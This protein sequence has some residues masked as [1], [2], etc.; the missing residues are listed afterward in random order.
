M[1]ASRDWKGE[2]DLV[3]ARMINEQVYCPRLAHLEWVQGEFR[4]SADTLEGRLAHR[5]VDREEGAVPPPEELPEDLRRARSLTL[6]APEL[7]VVA[8]IDAVEMAGGEIVPLDVKKGRAPDLP[9]GAWAPE[10]A[11]VAA[12]V[13]VLRENGYRVPHGLLYF[14]SSKRRVQVLID[15]ELERLVREAVAALREG[16]RSG[17]LPP[18][19]ED[20]PKCPRCSLAGIC[21]PDEVRFLARA[22][23]KGEVRRLFPARDDQLPLVV[24]EQGARVG[25]RGDQLVVAGPD[26]TKAEVR[27]LEVSQVA[28][29]GNVSMS[30]QALAELLDRGIPTCHFSLG[31]WFRGMTGALTRSVDLRRAQYRLMDDWEVGG[32]IAR[33]LVVGKILN[34]RTLL[35]RNGR[36]DVGE[37]VAELRRLARAAAKAR[38]AASLLGVEGLAARVYFSAFPS[39]I[40]RESE[41]GTFDFKGRNRRPPKDPVNALLSFAYALLIKDAAIAAQVVGFDPHAGLYHRPRPGK[42]AFAL[43]LAEEFRPLIADSVV[44]AALNNGEIRRSHFVVRGTACSLNS[45]GRKA[46]ISAYE[47]RM[48]TLVRHPTF[49]YS[50]GYRRVIEVQARLMAR[51]LL[52]ELPAYVP[53][54]TR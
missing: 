45:E 23:T 3:P 12:Q 33:A 50:I 21:L 31:G 5:R 35:R 20:S 39:L 48:D 37:P 51:C 18:P 24:Q 1:E 34:Q 27:L 19:L 49:G 9:E 40:R 46:L 17:R 15:E 8:R 11:Q 29:F 32:D 13:L 52:G 22:G 6:S 16:A 28:L 47:R 41:V 10:R 43:D 4:H 2:T 54:R 36:D 25:K 44:L 7:G 38:E 30:A 53:F 14:A 26:G 42:P